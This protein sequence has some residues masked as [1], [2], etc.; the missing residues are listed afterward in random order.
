M[1]QLDCTVIEPPNRSVLE[2]RIQATPLSNLTLHL[3]VVEQPDE[4][5]IRPHRKV[6]GDDSVPLVFAPD[7]IEAASMYHGR[8]RWVSLNPNEIYKYGRLMMIG[9]AV[10]YAIAYRDTPS[11]ERMAA[12]LQVEHDGRLTLEAIESDAMEDDSAEWPAF[13]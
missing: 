1:R 9:A 12:F 4:L 11:T 7:V 10:F 5:S 3:L 13:E 8:L 2:Q 6:N